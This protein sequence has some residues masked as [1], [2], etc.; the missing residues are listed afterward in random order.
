[1]VTPFK[2][3]AL[4]GHVLETKEDLS[5]EVCTYQCE[6]E[7]K[8]FSVN[9]RT[10]SRKCELNFASK[11]MFPKDL[12]E[13]KNSLYIHNIRKERTDACQELSC[14]NGGSCYPLPRPR[15]LCPV[16]FQGPTCEST[17]KLFAYTY[18]NLKRRIAGY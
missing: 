3:R 1:M 8:C 18:C 10:K 9:F 12:V 17:C 13:E 5:F 11:E 15:C 14:R 2:N 4:L 7:D 16:A 6:V